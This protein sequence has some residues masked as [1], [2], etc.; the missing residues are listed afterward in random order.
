MDFSTPFPYLGLSHSILLIS[1]RRKITLLICRVRIIVNEYETALFN[2]TIEDILSQ[3][4]KNAIE[5]RSFHG[6]P[7]QDYTTVYRLINS[8]GD[9]FSGLTADV[10]NNI[11]VIQSSAYWT[12]RHKDMILSC[13][14]KAMPS[15]FE[16]IWKQS[17]SF[18]QQDGF[19]PPTAVDAPTADSAAI[20][21]FENGIQFSVNPGK[22]QKT[23]F[24]CDQRDNRRI[25]RS[26]CRGNIA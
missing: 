23:G 26:M 21:V 13:F 11:V 4:I 15:D 14:Q 12:E 5:L 10:F 22:G 6:I 9:F 25:I 18:L 3:R 1:E 20:C 7:Q 17:S 19:Y 24:Y 2:S 8:E 16:F